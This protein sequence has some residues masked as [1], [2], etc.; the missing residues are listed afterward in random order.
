MPS[1]D[2]VV[3]CVSCTKSIYI[4]GK[5]PHYLIDLLFAYE[6]EPKTFEPNG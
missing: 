5:N 4:G 2:V 6:T 1:D 3:Y